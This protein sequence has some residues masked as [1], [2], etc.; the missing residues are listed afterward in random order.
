MFEIINDKSKFV[1]MGPASDF[2]NLNKI[3]KGDNKYT[4]RLGIQ[5]RR[6][7]CFNE[8][9]PLGSIRPKLYGLPKLHKKKSSFEVNLSMTKSYVTS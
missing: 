7:E 3:K 6:Q 2:D 5:E 1:K 9:K 8:N 4:E